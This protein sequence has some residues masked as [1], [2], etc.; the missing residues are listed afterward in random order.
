MPTMLHESI[1]WNKTLSNLLFLLHGVSSPVMSPST[2]H[3]R[4]LTEFSIL[5][6][7]GLLGVLD[8]LVLLHC[9][10]YFALEYDPLFREKKQD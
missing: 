8:S 5:D 9:H 2:M 3:L 10:F 1:A 4:F 7:P 6:L